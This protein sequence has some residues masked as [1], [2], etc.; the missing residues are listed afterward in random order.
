VEIIRVTRTSRRIAIALSPLLVA[1]GGAAAS[2]VV[3]PQGMSAA[4]DTSGQALVPPGFGTLRQDDIALKTQLTSTLV[5]AIPLDESVIRTLS[6]DSYRALHELAEGH[7]EQIASLAARH[8]IRRPSLWYVTYYGLAPEA[9]FDP[10]DFVLQ[11]AGRDFRPVEVIPLSA[12]FRDQ[13]VR[14]RDT[15]TA[16]YM[17]ED[18]VNVNQTLTLTV[19]GVQ[20]TT[21]DG[22]LRTIER[23]RSLIRSRAAK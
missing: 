11:S 12:G 4:Q 13:R 22:I 5:R 3:V 17:F 18:G 14:Q 15:Q 21:W 7:R 6:P 23:E 16:I 10:T 8:N 2:S 1:C 9:R 20:N 19:E